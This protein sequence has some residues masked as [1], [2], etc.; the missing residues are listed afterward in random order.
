LIVAIRRSVASRGDALQALDRRQLDELAFVNQGAGRI[1]AEQADDL[2]R[3][4]DLRR[5]GREGLDDGGDLRGVL[6]ALARHP[7]RLHARA[8]GAQGVQ[9]VHIRERRID[10]LDA[11]ERR[12]VNHPRARIEERLPRH[13]AS[14]CR[15]QV[16]AAEVEGLQARRGA[17]DRG[18][19]LEPGSGLD[20]REELRGAAGL[21]DHRGRTAR[22][23]GG[24]DLRQ[25]QSV[26]RFGACQ[27]AQ[28]VLAFGARERVHARDQPNAF[29]SA[30]GREARK[31]RGARL[32][33]AAG[34]HR[35]LEVDADDVGTARHGG[36]EV[37]E[38]ESADEERRAPLR[39][40]GHH[41][42]WGAF[43]M[44]S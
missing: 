6:R 34:R 43:S 26:E 18:A 40:T 38:D 27:L 25:H 3:V 35:V 24:F 23:V 28:V 10:R 8:I 42:G 13:R 9:V 5:R 31:D 1:G 37:A 39:G 41:A 14:E 36:I 22:L 21:L 44:L 4:R 20:D 33:L 17:R 2:A 29:G 11:A 7:E 16:E 15:R 12:R 32:V 30:E 19:V